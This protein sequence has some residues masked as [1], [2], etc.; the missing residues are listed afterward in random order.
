MLPESGCRRTDRAR[1]GGK[2]RHDAMHRDRAQ[3]L[4][5][6]VRDDFAR[7]HV[8]IGHDLRDVVDGAHRHFMPVEEREILVECHAADEFTDDGVQ[9]GC[10]LYPFGIGT[11]ARVVDQVGAPDDA[12]QPFGHRLRGRRHAH[13]LPVPGAVGVARRRG[14]RA[15]ARARTQFA[16]GA[17]ARRL[18]TH[19]REERLE[20]R[21]IYHLTAAAAHF[22][23]PQR[24][25]HGIRAVRP[26]RAVRK[27]H[28]RQH[29]FAVLEAVE[30]G[31]AGHA[32]GERAEAR[33][34]PVGTGLSPSGDAHDDELRIARVQH[35]GRKPHLLQ[36]P[37]PEVLDENLRGFR[38]PQE[39]L[40][41]FGLS[42]VEAHALLVAG[43][44][45]PVGRD[46][47]DQPVAQRVA[48]RRFDLDHLRPEIGKQQAQHIARHHAREIEH[49]HA[50]ERA[51]RRGIEVLAG[52]GSLAGHRDGQTVS[53]AA[54]SAGVGA[55]G[56][57]FFDEPRFV[58][59][60]H[61]Q[62]CNALF[63]HPARYGRN[64]QRRERHA[65]AVV[66]RLSDRPHTGERRRFAHGVAELLR[67][68]DLRGEACRGEP[69]LRE[70]RRIAGDDVPD[71]LVGQRGKYGEA[72]DAYAERPAHAD[73]EREGLDRKCALAPVEAQAVEAAALRKKSGI[74]GR[75]RDPR[76]RRVADLAQV[77]ARRGSQP[78]LEHHGAEK[79]TV[80]I[81]ILLHH[82]LCRETL[83]HAVHRG[84]L[85]SRPRRK[86]EQ[87]RAVAV[88]RGDLTEQYQRALDALR[89][90][91][92]AGREAG[93]SGHG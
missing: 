60:N 10:I 65:A 84:P 92:L 45:L 42:Q 68:L 38:E 50:G 88:V 39:Q 61:R 12:K 40:P 3:L 89:S 18:R 70:P 54:G 83:Q 31:E 8:R 36:R 81:E 34:M 22:D 15:A 48:L 17:M 77:E 67:F 82:V 74:A 29:G 72:A 90:G 46:A 35:L 1:R 56:K 64:R 80:R 93:S 76:E 78:Q 5:G 59:Q 41:R 71:L 2:R 19:E 53:V 7:A 27:L 14:R 23:V 37:G 20:E 75:F 44:D 33:L 43:V 6:I 57:L 62:L 87:A 4:V 47:V 25:Q 58:L 49:P 51:G 55:Y 79:I 28:R 11:V 85:Q 13:P 32:L 26:G 21:E 66:Q 69:V 73:F 30:R 24:Q 9:F 52:Q 63:R 86:V 91:Q 16:A